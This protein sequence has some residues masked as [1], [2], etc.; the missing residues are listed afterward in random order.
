MNTE[1]WYETL[2]GAAMLVAGIYMMF[3]LGALV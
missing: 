1:P 2:A 3:Y